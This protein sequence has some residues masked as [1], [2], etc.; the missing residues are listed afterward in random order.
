MNN[1][2][3][4]SITNGSAYIKFSELEFTLVESFDNQ[5]KR[6]IICSS[7]MTAITQNLL[8]S[9][10]WRHFSFLTHNQSHNQSPLVLATLQLILLLVYSIH[11]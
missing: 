6:V 4:G 10:Y 9:S 7:D 5:N 11:L 1:D 8:R 2:D 3:H